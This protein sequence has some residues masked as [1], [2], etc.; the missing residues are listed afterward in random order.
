MKMNLIFQWDI[1]GNLFWIFCLFIA[2]VHLA[3]SCTYNTCVT[4]MQHIVTLHHY[5]L[6]KIHLENNWVTA[7]IVNNVIKLATCLIL[8]ENIVSSLLGYILDCILAFCIFFLQIW[9]IQKQLEVNHGPFSDF[10]VYHIILKPLWSQ[11]FT[12]ATEL[13]LEAFLE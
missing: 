8:V 1:L 4:V 3:Y 10:L 12:H 6:G 7:T 13:S 2:W 11:I 9:I 5:L